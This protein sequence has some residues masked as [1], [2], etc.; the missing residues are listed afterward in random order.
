MDAS[1]NSV[2]SFGKRETRFKGASKKTELGK[3]HDSAQGSKSV[4]FERRGLKERWRH[5][6]T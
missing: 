5:K 3:G 2:T 4:V 1:V 6:K